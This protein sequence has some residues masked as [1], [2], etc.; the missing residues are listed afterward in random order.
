MIRFV[1]RRSTQRIYM[2]VSEN[3][4]LYNPEKIYVTLE[5]TFHDK[6][7]DGLYV[8]KPGDKFVLLKNDYLR[9]FNPEVK[10]MTDI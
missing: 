4:C 2:F 3:K 10:F 1:T 6:S 7:S 9:E 5:Q 8:S